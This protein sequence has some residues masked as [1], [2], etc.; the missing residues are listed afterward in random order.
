MLPEGASMIRVYF[1]FE[2]PNDEELVNLSYIDVPTTDPSEA[3]FRVEQ[4]A[5][6]GELWENMFPDEE[7]RPYTLIKSKMIYLDISTLVRE[8]HAETTLA[9]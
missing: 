2:D 4:A 9:S 7:D 8:H 3:F 1:V 6:S 5:E